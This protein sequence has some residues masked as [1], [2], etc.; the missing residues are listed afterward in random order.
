MSAVSVVAV[1]YVTIGSLCCTFMYHIPTW[2]MIFLLF[3]TIKIVFDYR[4]CT[5]AYLECR[6]RGVPRDEGVLNYVLDSI[7]DLR[8]EPMMCG[9]LL[10]AVAYM[11]LQWFYFTT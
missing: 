9:I 10:V 8:E 6:M 2:Y 1:L 11:V 7:V 3:F 5:V 4:R